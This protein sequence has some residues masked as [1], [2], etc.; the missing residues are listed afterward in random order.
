[1]SSVSASDVNGTDNYTVDEGYSD[2]DLLADSANAI[3]VDDSLGDDSNDGESWQSSVKSFNKALELAKDSDSIYIADGNYNGLD[4][5]QIIISKSVNVIGSQNTVFNGSN[6]NFIFNISDNVE[7]TFKNIKFVNAFKQSTYWQDS[8]MY[9]GALEINKATV[10][11]DNCSFIDNTVSYESSVNKLN[12]GGAISN[13]GDLTILN[14]YFD[15]NVA[16]ST[17]GLFSY[18]G[19]IYNKG[20]LRINSTVF[21]NSKTWD[22]GYGGAI[23]ND[24]NLV[25]DNG[26]FA[27]AFSSQESKGSV[28]Y[29]AGNCTLLNSIIENNTISKANFYY[30][31][32]AIY[33][34]GNLIAK[35]NIFRNNSGIYQAPNPEYRGS[36]NIYSTGN[37]N[38]T[39]NMFIDNAPFNG[40]GTDVYF[41][42]GREIFL[43]NNWW[44]T[45]DNPF[46]SNK[47]NVNDK[48]SSWLIFNLTPEYSA[49][50]ATQSAVIT[51]FWSSN[52]PLPIDVNSIPLLNVT[53]TTQV[54]DELIAQTCPLSGG[55]ATFNFTYSQNKGAYDVKANIGNYEQK[56]IVDVGKI[57][58]HIQFNFTDNII[59]TDDFVLD[60]EV[61][62]DDLNIPNGNV[63]VFIGENYYVIKLE[64]GKGSLSLQNLT[65]KNYSL[66]LVYEGS[67]DYFKAYDYANLTIR[68]APTILNISIED[69]K[70]DQKGIARIY[71]GPTGIQGQ[72]IV[73]ING[74]RKKIVYLY[75]GETNVTFNNLAEGQYDLSVE[76]LGN[77]CFDVSIANATFKV[78]KYDTSLTINVSDIKKGETQI[79][80]IIT[81]PDNLAG[82][83]ILSING[84]NSTIFLEGGIT[85]ITVSNLEPGSY[86]VAVFYAENSRYYASSA[87]ASFRVS[88]IFTNL[89]VDITEN[90]LNAKIVVKTN[91]TGC[92]GIAGVYVNFR[93][94]T[95]YLNKGVANFNVTL[96]KGTNY[97]FVYYEGDD[98]YEG[99]TWNTTLGVDD[100]FIFIGQNVTG[101]EHN[102][103]NYTIRLIE[104]NGIPMP[105]RT[106][107]V[108]LENQNY[109]IK[110]NDEGI[111]CLPLNLQEG[112]YE[113]SASYKNQT[114][115]NR[116]SI[117]KIEFNVTTQDTQYSLNETIKVDFDRNL[118]GK[119]NI[120]IQDY[121]NVTIDIIDGSVTYNI[122]TLKVGNYEA[123]VKYVNEYFSSAEKS[124]GFRVDKITPAVDLDISDVVYGTEGMII[125]NLPDDATGTI[126]F[127]IDGAEYSKD[128]SEGKSQINLTNMDKGTHNVTVSYSGD[129]NFNNVTINSSFN[130]KDKCSDLRLLIND[131]AYGE[132]INVVAILDENATGNVIFNVS[133]I[134]K[135]VEIKNGI[136]NCTFTGLNAGDYVL[137]A[138]YLGDSIY[139]SSKNSTSFKV[140]KS[141]STVEVYVNEVFLNE[142]IRIYARVSPNATGTVSFSMIDYYSP[143]NKAISN[144]IA[145]WYISPLST[146]NYTVVARYNGD[147]NYYASETTYILQITQ[148]K[149]ILTVDIPDVGINDRVVVNI[150]LFASDN[151]PITGQVNLTIDTTNYR[152]NVNNGKA[153]LVLGRLAPKNYNYSASYAGSDEYSKDSVSGTFK[154]VNDTLKLTLTANNMTVFYGT[155]KNLVV[156]VAYEKQA[157]SGIT[158]VVKINGATLTRV[159]DDKGKIQIP[160]KNLNVGEYPIQI[161]F[162]ETGRYQSAS[163]N[164]HVNVLTTVEAVDVVK[165]FGSATQYYA[166]FTDSNGKALANT[167]IKLTVG[168]NSYT[169]TTLPN[170][171][172]RVNIN[173]NPGKYS[174]TAVNPATGQKVTTSLYIFL[175]LMGNKDVVKY[176]GGSQTYKVRAYDNNGNPVGAGKTVT[177]KLNGKTYNVKT[178]KNGYAACKLNLKPKTYAITATYNGFKVSNKI[179]VKP[180]LTAKNISKKKGKKIK[181]KAKLVNKNGKA[182]KGK[183][184]TFKFKGKKYKVKTN[185]KGFAVLKLKLKLKV[186]KHKIISKYGKFKIANTIKIK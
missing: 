6:I 184:I 30:I 51:A 170:G 23:Y 97:I 4:N 169:V 98:N 28:I 59:Y 78:T 26:I 66:K 144:S 1:M 27:N 50:N 21:N 84:V 69:I 53:F 156:S 183:K 14:S 36:G 52:S 181:F 77:D 125:A 16:T 138:K 89:T 130:V 86:D 155:E 11:I 87:S 121:L 135:T 177:F 25:I 173:F 46:K 176:Y 31:Y 55:S 100:E 172:V 22:F 108:T 43:E 117:N 72:A 49:L 178:D 38:L 3:Y 24:G 60:V 42:G 175:K 136:A 122:S 166:I 146:G 123:I 150:K 90:G 127:I 18:G 151:E 129:S 19:A 29:N 164:V 34:A 113:I 81:T 179:K 134:I 132:E 186:G 91:Y 82:S 159:T 83:A 95:L 92:T 2:L 185:K 112:V 162:E 44:G 116:L 73:Y 12:F 61:T 168:S 48:I 147:N 85:N 56:V 104:P 67:D 111:A 33:N 9:G 64:E 13:L 41:N 99:A 141:N 161:I 70:I 160:L 58:S 93:A 148:R 37:L 145:S 40:I 174:V 180:V 7:V 15:N 10:C 124:S 171:I 35:G 163:T 153:T 62:S 68:K 128:V 63:S 120:F 133:N 17:S 118:T 110:T 154:V 140:L 20:K 167:D 182:V 57:V 101:F 54:G 109:T 75:N 114:I 137:N 158:L 96:D 149:S 5:T 165:L 143:R 88:K 157:I 131:S 106:V 47:I 74:V 94:Y 103:F 45:N 102:D 105:Q 80:S 107:T 152:I 65:P 119:A 139:I 142:N 76:F 115:T 39:Y 126:L 71:L 79:I 8:S 32:G